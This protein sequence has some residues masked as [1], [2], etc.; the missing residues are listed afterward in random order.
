MKGIA[1]ASLLFLV[2]SCSSNNDEKL[3]QAYVEKFVENCSKVTFKE[4]CTCQATKVANDLPHEDWGNKEKVRRHVF[5]VTPNCLQDYL[6]KVNSNIKIP[7][8]TT[9]NRSPE[10]QTSPK[11]P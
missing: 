3:K 9:P 4:V 7:G 8:A 6:S 5:E 2:A 10:D 11:Q 1:V